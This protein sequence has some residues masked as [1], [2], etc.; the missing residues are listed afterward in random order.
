MLS[1][2]EIASLTREQ[3]IDL[4]HRLAAFN[5]SLVRD[6]EES[7]RRRRRIIDLLVITCLGLIP[8]IV[9]LGLTL[10]SRYSANHWTVAW[11]G[12]DVGLLCALA[13]TAWAAW[14]RRQIV[15]IAALVTGTM[16]VIDAWFDIVTD[17]TT[18]D[19]IISL[20]TAVFAELPLAALTFV[21]AF[22]LI[23]LTT[24]TARALAGERDDLPLRKVPLLGI[25][26]IDFLGRSEPSR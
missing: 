13:V 3:R 24:R 12:F 20:V 14:R 4:T 26:P 22:R 2:S 5:D 6:T 18:R 23:R 1:D 16:L 7:R 8:W 15:I 25:D 19:L 10:P 17:S 9:L 11:V 21:G